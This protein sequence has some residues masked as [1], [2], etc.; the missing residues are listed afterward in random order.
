MSEK[1]GDVQLKN[2]G[3]KSKTIVTW[4]NIKCEGSEEKKKQCEGVSIQFQQVEMD[5]NDVLFWSTTKIR[6]PRN[7]RRQSY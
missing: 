2:E 6:C 1:K 7:C 4:H 5:W 3:E